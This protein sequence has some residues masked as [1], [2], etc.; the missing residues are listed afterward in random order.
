MIDYTEQQHQTWQILYDRRMADLST[1]ASRMFLEGAEAI[2]LER[3]R[4]PDLGE[5]NRRLRN[6]TGW[7][8]V[9]VGGFIPAS[10]FFA[11]LARREFP[12]VVTIRDRD[13]LDYIPEP[14]IFHDLFGHV[15][16][17]SHPVFADFLQ[18]F[19]EMAMRQK[20]EIGI[21][22]M[23]RLFW[24]TVEFGLIHENGAPRV[25]GS[26]L[27]SSQADCA[28]ALSDR[29]DR[30][31]FSLEAVMSQPF[32]IDHVQDV[33]FTIESFEDLFKAIESDP[34]KV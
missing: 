1:R 32:E 28:N 12:T 19:G 25:Y 22:R 34:L 18:R 14:D 15:P 13:R 9:E 21:T 2:G 33:L 11:M 17:H 4:I 5:V 23:T 20:D 30:R 31:P 6:R 29:C 10:D 27:I 24:F 26:G 3:E 7:Q 8:A 16:L